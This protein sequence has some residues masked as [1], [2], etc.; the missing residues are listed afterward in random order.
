[1]LKNE[2]MIEKKKIIYRRGRLCT[3]TNNREKNT[4]I[5]MQE[6]EENQKNERNV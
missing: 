1:M 6:Y 3:I 2:T 4:E 5:G